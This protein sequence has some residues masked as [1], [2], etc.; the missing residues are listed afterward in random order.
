MGAHVQISELSH[1]YASRGPWV[2]E[3]IDLEIQ[4]G[5][6][7]AL[8]GR[9]GCGKS[10]LLQLA[11]GMAQPRRGS[12]W[13]DGRKVAKPSSKWNV[14][15]Q[16]PSLYPWLNVSQNAALGMK[17]AGASVLAKQRVPDLLELVEMTDYATQNVQRLSGGQQQRVALA[18]SLATDPDL[19][20]LDEPFSSLDILTRRN[21]QRDVVRI[22]RERGI[23][24]VLVTHDTEEAVNVADRILVM[25]P[26]PG[27]IVRQ[28][29]VDLG[30]ERDSG[31]DRFKEV[32]ADLLRDLTTLH[33][34]EA[35]E[36]A[37]SVLA[38]QAPRATGLETSLAWRGET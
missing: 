7:V 34:P 12:V 35:P 11:A 20:L 17:L 19:L 24:L 5:E 1:R 23:S 22:V 13:I 3:D 37:P 33:V 6:R 14:M 4:P 10:T 15:F 9:S 31:S 32:E 38:A 26:N 25:A 16:R 28:I 29:D 18:R 2:L 36:R 27:R 8:V 21:L 30:A